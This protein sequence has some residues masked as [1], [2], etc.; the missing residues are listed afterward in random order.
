M[1]TEPALLSL[2]FIGISQV[3]VYMYFY[4]VRYLCVN[5]IILF[6]GRVPMKL[7]PSLNNI[8]P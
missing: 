4:R 7:A 2:V 5:K 3:S 6:F 8:T 1:L